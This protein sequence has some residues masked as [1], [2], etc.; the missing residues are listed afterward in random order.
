MD[1]HAGGNKEDNN[2]KP[3]HDPIIAKMAVFGNMSRERAIICCSQNSV[4]PACRES[5]W[6][7][8]L[9]TYYSKAKKDSG[10]AG[11]IT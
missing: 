1:G 8:T 2:K 5:L 10:Q 9:N 7:N 11:M 3:S 6:G 4:I